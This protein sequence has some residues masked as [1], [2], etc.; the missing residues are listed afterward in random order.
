MIAIVLIWDL[1]THMCVQ[2]MSS[3]KRGMNNVVLHTNLG[4]N[5]RAILVQAWP[6]LS[7]A[8]LL[9]HW[10]M[11]SDALNLSSNSSLRIATQCHHHP[12]NIVAKNATKLHPLFIMSA[13]AYWDALNHSLYFS[14]WQWW[15]KSPSNISRAFLHCK[16]FTATCA[17]IYSSLCPVPPKDGFNLNSMSSLSH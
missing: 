4:I 12:T 9:W 3:K 7:G 15:W 5:Q 8:C 10:P 2:S 1:I 13:N 6:V 11:H 17:S 14:L 16:S